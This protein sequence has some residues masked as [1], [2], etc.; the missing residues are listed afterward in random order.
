MNPYFIFGLFSLAALGGLYLLALVLQKKETPKLVAFIHGI[1][2]AAAL[3]LLFAYAM[4]FEGN[5]TTC[6]VTFVVAALGGFVLI[7]RDLMGR[8]IPRWLAV[9]H[10][11]VAVCGLVLLAVEIF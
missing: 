6:L 10:G 1:A 9:V 3:I 4:N 7:A 2:A 5:F 11:L 8:S